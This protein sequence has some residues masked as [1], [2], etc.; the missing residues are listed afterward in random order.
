MLSA[1]KKIKKFGSISPIHIEKKRKYKNKLFVE[2]KL[3]NGQ[4]MLFDTKTFKKLKGF[5]ENYFLYYEKMIF[6]KD[7]TC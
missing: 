7:A 2:E 3:I 5:D 4:A 6:L 1:C